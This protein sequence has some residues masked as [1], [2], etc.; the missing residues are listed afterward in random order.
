MDASA[1]TIARLREEVDTLKA[2]NAELRA[3]L[4]GARWSPPV[5][6]GLTGGEVSMVRVLVAR[7]IASRDALVDAIY[8]SRG[9]DEPDSNSLQARMSRLRGKVAAFGIEIR[10]R[11]GQG[12]F[13]PAEQRAAI[14]AGA[15][16]LRG[17]AAAIPVHPV[18]PSRSSDCATMPR[19]GAT[20]HENGN[21]KFSG[22]SL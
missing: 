7:E 13:L 19:R 6:W 3:E 2:E 10:T 9:R 18:A 16:D 5:E 4:L 8:W 12:W 15:A 17:T 20:F 22:L 1:T 11:W 21:G 14:A